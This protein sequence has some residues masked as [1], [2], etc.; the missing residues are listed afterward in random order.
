M[1]A[2][3]TTGPTLS[4]TSNHPH[5]SSVSPLRPPRPRRELLHGRRPRVDDLLADRYSLRSKSRASMQPSTPSLARSSARHVRTSS[6]NLASTPS[7]NR[8]ASISR[9]RRVQVGAPPFRPRGTFAYFVLLPFLNCCARSEAE[10][11]TA[12]AGRADRPR[13]CA[14]GAGRANT[15]LPRCALSVERTI[16][17]SSLELIVPA[18]SDC[19]QACVGSSIS[20]KRASFRS[21]SKR[22]STTRSSAITFSPT[23]TIAIYAPSNRRL[24]GARGTA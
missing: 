23:S 8:S 19:C 2:A 1:R 7:P 12:H 11:T 16:A 24:T 5:T 15:C 10:A 13:G 3:F 21:S 22:S 14:P 4:N 9:T 18:R 17:Q 6:T 20:A